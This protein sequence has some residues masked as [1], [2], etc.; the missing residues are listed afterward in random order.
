LEN[1]IIE[2]V[3]WVNK[4]LDWQCSDAHKIKHIINGIIFAKIQIDK[5]QHIEFRTEQQK[6][7]VNNDI[8]S[9]INN[10]NEKLNIHIKDCYLPF[11]TDDY[12]KNMKTLLIDLKT[13]EK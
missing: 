12:I 4:T 11:Y 9:M 8:I 10:F 6:L 2:L 13:D 3:E 5:F 1:S 7:L